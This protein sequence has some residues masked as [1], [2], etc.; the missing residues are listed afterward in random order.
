MSITYQVLGE[1]GRDNALLVHVNSGQAIDRFL[2]DCGDV[3]LT[4]LPLAE[5]KAIDH[6]FFSHLHMDHIGGFDTYFRSLYD[7]TDKPNVIWG[8]AQTREIIHHRFR[9]FLWNLYH[10]HQASWQVRDIDEQ[11]VCSS[12][13]ELAEAFAVAHDEGC[14]ERGGQLL[15]GATYTI[16]AIQLDHMTPSLGYIVREQ[17]RLNIDTGRL[18]ALGL[19][20]GPW[21]KEVKTLSHQEMIVIDG[22]AHDPDVLRREL[23]ISSPGSCLAYLTDFLPDE[24]A[25]ERLVPFLY[26]C[27]TLICE[28]QYLQRDLAL[29]QRNYHLTAVRAAELARVVQAEHLVLFHISERYTREEWLEMLEQA[30]AIFPETTFP[31]EWKL[32]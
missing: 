19:R 9:G 4:S 31:K 24:T 14:E 26:D 15:E 5:V 23:L 8:P 18:E 21:L 11:Q 12:R 29:A 7:R 6:L 10:E 22:I 17:P 3:G 25:M 2:F 28:S 20:S 1:A 13:Y 30:R 32:G 16:D 27:N